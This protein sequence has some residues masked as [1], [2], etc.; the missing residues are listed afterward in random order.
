[1][2]YITIYISAFTKDTRPYISNVK[3]TRS[4]T[5]LWDAG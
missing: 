1:L 3:R 4:L 2:L 5:V